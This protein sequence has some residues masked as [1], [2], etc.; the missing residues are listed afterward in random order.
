MNAIFITVDL[1]ARA[2]LAVVLIMA[3]LLKLFDFT[4][5]SDNFQ[6]FELFKNALFQ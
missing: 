5:T 4:F 1:S 6:K 3:G 2:L